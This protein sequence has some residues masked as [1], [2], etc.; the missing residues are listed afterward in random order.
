MKRHSMIAI[1]LGLLGLGAAALA[2]A[3]MTTL[4]DRPEAAGGRYLAQLSS[5]AI[6]PDA[7]IP[8]KFVTVSPPLAW[9]AVPGAAS[10]VVIVEDTDA[11]N[12]KLGMPFLHWLAW[13][14]PYNVT[15]LPEG[16]SGMRGT[17][18]VEGRNGAG[19]IGYF[20]PHPPPGP[21]HRYHFE[22]LAISNVLNLPAGASRDDVLKAIR[23]LAVGEGEFIGF[24]ANGR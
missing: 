5:P 23:G 2:G 17:K 22:I 21:P 4:I 15:S 19:K 18:L 1:A 8:K 24:Y 3:Q 13:N 16:A 14:I 10:Y 9:K 7:Y 20:G 6:K 12:R 11:G